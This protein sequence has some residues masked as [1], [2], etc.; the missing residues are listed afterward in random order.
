MNYHASNIYPNIY[1][2]TLRHLSFEPVIGNNRSL[3]LV[4][5]LILV[6]MRIRNLASVK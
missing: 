2:R 4:L 5:Y 3:D 6:Y 1:F